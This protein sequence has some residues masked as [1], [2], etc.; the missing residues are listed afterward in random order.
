VRGLAPYRDKV[1][2]NCGDKP[3]LLPAGRKY[4]KEMCRME[5][6]KI[7]QMPGMTPEQAYGA[8]T[9][10]NRIT[11][12]YFDSMLIEYR[13][14]GASK[15][16]TSFHFL[17]KTFS[18]PIMVGGMAAMVPGLHEGGMAEMAR[19]AVKMNTVMWTGYISDEEFNAVLA[20]GA[21]A[22]RI[23]KPMQDHGRILRAIRNDEEHGALAF[24]MDIDHGFNDEGEYLKAVPHAYSDLSPKTIDDLKE[25]TASTSLPF[26]AKGILSLSDA[27]A[28]VEAGAKALVLSHH[29][30]ENRCAVPPVYALQKIRPEIPEDIPIIVDCGIL[31]GLEAYK[32]LALGAS[33]VCTAR[34]L[35]K[36]FAQQGGEGV[37]QFLDKMNRELKGYMGKTSIASLGEMTPDVICWKHSWGR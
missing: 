3:L 14:I 5:L 11:K 17:G 32:A 10:S 9:D 27:K 37:W 33:G 16:D 26:I 34:P 2:T 15:P 18:T 1:S 13:Y 4:V 25:F 28:C 24:A 19:G 7:T 6:E 20:T 22:I 12:E 36:P 23:I 35:M 8:A 29:K 30:G 21:D 31:S